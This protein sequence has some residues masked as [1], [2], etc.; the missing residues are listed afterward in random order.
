MRDAR[1]HRVIVVKEG[2]LVGIIS[3]LDLAG[4]IAEGRVEV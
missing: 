4:L 3:S 2:Y 1:I